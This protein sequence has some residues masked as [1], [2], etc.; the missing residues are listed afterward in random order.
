MKLRDRSG[1]FR[2]ALF[3]CSC[4]HVSYEMIP[5]GTA[6]MRFHCHEC[7]EVGRIA[8]ELP[9]YVILITEEY[10]DVPLVPVLRPLLKRG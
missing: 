10:D 5:A 9:S 8:T 4:G 2:N 6:S 7:G 3:D 1:D